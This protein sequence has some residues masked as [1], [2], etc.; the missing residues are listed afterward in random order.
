MPFRTRERHRCGVTFHVCGVARPLLAVT[1]LTRKGNQVV[2]E[3][4][5]GR[6]VGPDGKQTIEAC[7]ARLGQTQV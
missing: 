3:K 6:I 4:E 5:G 2:F 7:T 1:A